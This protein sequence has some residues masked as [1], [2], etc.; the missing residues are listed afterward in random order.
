MRGGARLH[1]GE[2]SRPWTLNSQVRQALAGTVP[3]ACWEQHST[4]HCRTWHQA[5][6]TAGGHRCSNSCVTDSE[7]KHTLHQ[8]KVPPPSSRPA[9]A[10]RQ[11]EDLRTAHS[12]AA[13]GTPHPA[14]CGYCV[15][16]PAHGDPFAVALCR[17]PPVSQA[18]QS[19]LASTPRDGLK[20][21][22]FSVS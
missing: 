10:S 16:L 12:N 6:V 11:E 18:S 20:S 9:W 15:L 2:G 8:A 14:A 13:P 5:C 3:P 21:W 4:L 22:V 17:V 7:H 19:Q 1:L